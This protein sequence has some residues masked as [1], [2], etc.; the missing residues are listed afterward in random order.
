MSLNSSQKTNHNASY[1]ETNVRRLK[2]SVSVARARMHVRA[3]TH[4]HILKRCAGQCD[5]SEE[6]ARSHISWRGKLH[7]RLLCTSV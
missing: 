4:T 3:H 1:L 2:L 5:N 6:A 7:T